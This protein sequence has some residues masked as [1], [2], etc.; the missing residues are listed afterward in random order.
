[1]ATFT[2][3]ATLSYSGG[4]I[5]SNIAT[6]EIVEVLS[7]TKTAIIDEYSQGTQTT[8]AIN[9]VNSGNTAF[10]GL[11][12]TDNLGAYAFGATTLQPLEY[13]DSSL[14]YFV[15]GDLL[16]SPTVT[17]GPPLVISGLTVPANGVTTI[18]YAARTNAFA[19]TGADGTI[20]NTA[21]VSGNGI[22]NLTATETISARNEPNL[23]ITK[24]VSP[25]T[26]TENGQ[27]TYTFLI[28]NVGNT[29]ATVDDNVVIS[30]TFNPILSNISVSYNGTAWTSPD[31]YS[32]NT[33]TGLFTTN[34]GSITVPAGTVTQNADTGVWTVDPGVAT[35]TVTGTI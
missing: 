3:Q 6:G 21:T 24:S 27:I 2:N 29:A 26:V 10:T 18:L 23:T 1:M 12:L 34:A 17:A 14:K 28:Q 13:V 32:Y 20:E 9:I 35:L 5:N 16:A 31:D 7:V 30:D 25:T 4:T 19:P 11:T 8:Y 22:N 33:T 15:N